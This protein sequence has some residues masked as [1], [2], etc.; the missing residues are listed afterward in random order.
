MDSVREAKRAAR[1]D[2][3]AELSVNAL[4][5]APNADPLPVTVRVQLESQPLGDL[6]GTN[7]HY[8]EREEPSDQLVFL[9]DELP[10]PKRGAVV[11][12]APGE[13]YR[14]DTTLPPHDIT[15]TAKVTTLTEVE[16]EGL[17]IPESD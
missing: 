10:R 5:I 3:H 15:V 2:L 12:V 4:Y 1:R 14:I 11:S 9:L 7:F 16:A 8:T 17:P 6:K 13:A